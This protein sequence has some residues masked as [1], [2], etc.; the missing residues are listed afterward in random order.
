VLHG[1]SNP[2]TS[3]LVR[4]SDADEI[5]DYRIDILRLDRCFVVAPAIVGNCIFPSSLGSVSCQLMPPSLEKSTRDTPL[6][7]PNAMPRPERPSAGLK[8]M[9]QS[10]R[11][12]FGL[13]VK[14]PAE[15]VRFRSSAVDG[16]STGTRV[17]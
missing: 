3:R 4:A 16:S 8:L 1:K 12:A 10:S 15:S 7:P 6:S 13:A 17:P 9:K 5:I 14:L 2:T 11:A